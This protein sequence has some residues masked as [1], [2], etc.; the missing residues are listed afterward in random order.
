MIKNII[1]DL[2]NVVLTNDFQGNG[3][4]DFVKEFRKHF[5]I[6][7]ENEKK[8][9]YMI[10]PKF[11]T[12]KISENEFW[13]IF[14][15]ESGVKNIDIELAKSLWRKHQKPINDLFPLI[16]KLKKNYKLFS[17]ANTAKEWFEY[18]K[19]KYQLDKYF[20]EI[21]TSYEEGIKKPDVKIFNIAIERFQI[22]PQETLFIDDKE[23]NLKPARELGFNTILFKNKEQ[24]KQDLIKLEIK[25]EE[26]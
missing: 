23:R 20:E 21:V 22:K 3:L 4:N 1:F 2:G 8:A 7:E 10:W 26:E 19:E 24:L 12:G 14:F 13:K 17:I 15:T 9:W 18:K 16:K 25:L 6:N 11:E 5:N